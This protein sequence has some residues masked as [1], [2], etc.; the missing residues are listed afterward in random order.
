M[1]KKSENNQIEKD[2]IAKYLDTNSFFDLKTIVIK[3]LKINAPYPKPLDENELNE[4]SKNYNDLEGL[5]IQNSGIVCIDEEV[6]KKQSG[7]FMDMAKQ[8]TRGIF[9]GGT[10]SLSLP[11]RIFEPK[12]MLD[13]YS[14]VFKSAPYLLKKAASIKEAIERFK[15]VIIFAISGLLS[16]AGQLKPFNPMLGETWEGVFEDGSKIY[17]EHTCHN[18]CISNYLVLDKD[19]EYKIYGYNDISI[20]GVIS[21]VVNNYVSLIQKGKSNVQFIDTKQTISFHLPKIILGGIIHGQRYVLFDGH[22]KFED[23]RNGLKAYIFFNKSVNELKNSRFHD[24]YGTIFKHDFS[25]DSK[26]EEFLEVKPSKKTYNKDNLIS[27]I[28][29]SFL[30]EIK[31]NGQPYHNF[32]ESKMFKITPVEKS[33]P[34]DSRYREDLV[35]LKRSNIYPI[36]KKDYEEYA[37]QWKLAVEAQQRLERELRK[38]GIKK[39]KK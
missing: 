11:I 14:A 33:I 30:E 25:K 21:V 39:L 19:N 38:E 35:W 23:R 29:G 9:K 16:S 2:H 28:T 5:E 26:K 3:C 20:E 27:E 36:L 31:F 12:S 22:M 4:T 10:I 37:Q 1:E 15:Y 6:I 17:F 24:I 8:L 7:I 13:R 32:K 18:P 34:S